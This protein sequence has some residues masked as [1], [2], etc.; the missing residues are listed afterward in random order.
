MAKA[1]KEQPKSI[2]DKTK[3]YAKELVI[4][5]DKTMHKGQKIKGIK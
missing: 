5:H 1:K 2:L 4:R 3:K